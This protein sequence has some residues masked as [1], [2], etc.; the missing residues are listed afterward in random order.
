M[1]RDDH[2]V[3]RAAG[4]AGPHGQLGGPEDL[5]L[6]EDPRGARRGPLGRRGAARAA[7]S[8]TR[9]ASASRSTASGSGDLQRVPPA[10]RRRPGRHRGAR[11]AGDRGRAPAGRLAVAPAQPVGP[12]ADRDPGLHRRDLPRAGRRGQGAA[13][14]R[15]GDLATVSRPGRRPRLRPDVAGQGAAR[16]ARHPGHVRRAC[17][18]RCSRGATRSS[19][20]TSTPG[21]RRSRC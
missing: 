3:H 5:H 4:P 13:G 8:W 11:R 20:S 18:C 21:T 19:T 12:V 10:Q 6:P 14:H 9:R 16:R 7:T 1:S 17:C 15:Q 2:R